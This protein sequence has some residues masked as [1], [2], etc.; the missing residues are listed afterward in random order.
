MGIPQKNVIVRPD[1]GIEFFY[2]P[3]LVDKIF[4]SGEKLSIDGDTISRNGISY[5]IAELAAK[6]SAALT[7]EI[8]MHPTFKELFLDPVSKIV[9]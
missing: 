1:N 8:A 6:V 9:I 7:P 4:G 2:P 5:S 3:T